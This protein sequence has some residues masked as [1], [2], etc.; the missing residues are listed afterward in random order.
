MR[1]RA[2]FMSSSM[3]IYSD[4]PWIR[5]ADIRL[6]EAPAWQELDE[7]ASAW[8]GVSCLVLPSIRVGLCWAL[9]QRGYARH[10]DHILVPRFTG[11]CILN[12]LGRFSLPV[13]S[14]TEETRMAVV[15]NQFGRSQDLAALVAR[16]A[17]RDFSYI[18]DSPYGVGDDES[19]GKGSLGRFIGLGK[20]LPVVQGALFVSGDAAIS[21]QIELK[22]QQRSPWALPVWIT[23][24]LLRK[25]FSA[26]YSEMADA[27]Y[28]MYPASRGG[29]RY[30]RGNLSAVFN[31]IKW[32]EQ[33]SR[34]RMQVASEVLGAC[35]LLPDKQ[36]LGYVIPFFPGRSM[37]SMQ[38]ILSRLGFSDVPLHVDI[39]SNMLAPNYVK[40]LVVPVNPYIPRSS[41]DQLM[42]E[43]RKIPELR[44]GDGGVAA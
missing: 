7:I 32:F 42:N 19:L 22:R 16:F 36:R 6:F 44:S 21:R 33:E 3:Q 20:V 14:P 35:A 17:G 12:S 24:L 31:R 23:M 8:L 13:E 15:V 4:V 1:G 39:N 38:V 27:A 34:N 2:S 43:L 18:E 37:D 29:C 26:G 25:R 30:L 9:E 10:R 5:L 41:F 28:E 40:C 11:R